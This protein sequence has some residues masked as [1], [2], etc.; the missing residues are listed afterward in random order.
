M[1]HLVYFLLCVIS[2]QNTDAQEVNSVKI[3][4]DSNE[5]KKTLISPDS[6]HQL[7]QVVVSSKK[8]LYEVKID[9]TVINVDASPSNILFI[10]CNLPFTVSRLLSLPIFQQ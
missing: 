8:P 6:V 10:I 3:L 9:K 4:K 5:I 1:K 7:K 2:I